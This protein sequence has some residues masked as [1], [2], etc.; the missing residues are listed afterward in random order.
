MNITWLK[1][2]TAGADQLAIYKGGQGVE[3]GITENNT[4]LWS[5][6]QISSSAPQPL[7]HASSTEMTIYINF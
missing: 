7:G 3:L 2:R 1:L 5:D 6:L 4:S